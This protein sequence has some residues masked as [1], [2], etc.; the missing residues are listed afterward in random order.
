MAETGV[1]LFANAERDDARI[2]R[3]SGR[4]EDL[5]KF[6]EDVEWWVEGLDL[7]STRRYNLAVRFANKQTV[8]SVETRVR[9]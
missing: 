5:P 7:E 1:R 4:Y 3:F 9:S 2:P 6:K 8:P